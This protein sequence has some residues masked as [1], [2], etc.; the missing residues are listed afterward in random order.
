MSAAILGGKLYPVFKPN[1][2]NGRHLKKTTINRSSN[3][4][5]V[6]VDYCESD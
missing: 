3:I 1:E 6:G 2:L 4:P 5:G